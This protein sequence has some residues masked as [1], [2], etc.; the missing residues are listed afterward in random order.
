MSDEKNAAPEKVAALKRIHEQ[1]KGNSTATQR[2]RLRAAFHEL[3]RLST[4][5]IREGLDI[6]HP[7]GRVQELREDGLNIITLW[8]T[9]VSEGGEKH[10]V[11]DYVLGVEVAH[12]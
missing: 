4:V 3:R 1:F 8:T 9:V 7:A 10:R 12:A 2:D 5:E 6:I 11:A